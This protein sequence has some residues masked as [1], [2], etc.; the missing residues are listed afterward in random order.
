LWQDALVMQDLETKSL[1]S[2]ISG[3]CIQGKM[4]GTK[5]QQ[6]P[7]SHTTFGAFKK[8]YP[9]GK[10]LKKPADS[11]KGSPYDSYYADKD[12]LGMFGRVDNFQ[13]LK[14]KDKVYGLRFENKEVAVAE[15]YLKINGYVLVEN[16]SKRIYV[17][18]NDSRMSVAAFVLPDTVKLAGK[19]D[20]KELTTEQFPI[21]SAYW[22]AWVSFFPDTELI[23]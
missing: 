22:F 2:Q 17:S 5:L 1:W 3:I 19:F 13:K 20:L 4:E 11:Q 7:F 8:Q 14:G 9:N 6:V 16:D 23:K 15:S 10:L 18:Y 12:K 21:V